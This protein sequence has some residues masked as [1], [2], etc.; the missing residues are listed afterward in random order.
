MPTIGLCI[1]TNIGCT[2]RISDGGVYRNCNL[3]RALQEKCL[4]IPEPTLLPGTQ[5]LS[6]YVIVADDAFP[7]K[8]YIMKPFQPN[9]VDTGEKNFKSSTE[10]SSSGC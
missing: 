4:N 10:P 2:G 6:P 8:E 1:Y 5:S 9:R 7:L 3:F